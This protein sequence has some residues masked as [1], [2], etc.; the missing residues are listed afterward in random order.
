MKKIISFILI[1]I[2]LICSCSSSVNVNEPN[3]NTAPSTSETATNVETTTDNSTEETVGDG[4]EATTESTDDDSDQQTIIPSPNT[5]VA[6]PDKLHVNSDIAFSQNLSTQPLIDGSYLSEPLGNITPDSFKKHGKELKIYG[7]ISP[8]DSRVVQLESLLQS[9]TKNIALIVYRKDGTRALSYN[10]EQTFFSACTIKAGFILNVCKIIDSGAVDPDTLLAYAQ[11]HYHQGS[12]TIKKS[13]FG[14]QYSINELIIKCLSISDN[15]AY[16]MLLEHFGL[17]S[18]NKMITSLGCNSLKVSKMWASSALPMDYIV[19]WNEIYDYLQSNGRMVPVLKKACTN[20]PFNYGTLTLPDEIDY[21]HKSGDN[22][23]AAA[24][25][26][27][28]G[29]IWEDDAYIYSVFT[30]SEGKDYDLGMINS[31][32]DL[33]YEL[34]K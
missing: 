22:F 4:S 29:I 13:E 3:D 24:A 20:T 7:D 27:D 14:T 17:D 6:T 12:G 2:I 32:M 31:C 5:M 34:M 25:H 9:Y 1:T 28:A 19:V 15:V 11:R 18:Y 8:S 30:N 23:G 16:K 33:V 10:T 26:S 21:S